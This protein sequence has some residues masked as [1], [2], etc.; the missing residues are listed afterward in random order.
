MDSGIGVEHNPAMEERRTFRLRY[1][2]ARFAKHHLPVDVL[3]DLPAFRDLLVAYVKAGWRATH[4]ERVRLPRGFLRGL[5]FDL[6]GLEDGSAV[7]ALEWDSGNAQFHLPD[8]RDEMERLVDGACERVAQLFNGA[9]LADGPPT[10]SPDAL[11]ALNRFGNSLHKDERIEFLGHEDAEGKVVFLDA[12]RRRRLITQGR[13]TYQVRFDSVGRLL[14]TVIDASASSGRITINTEEHGTFELTVSPARA[15]EEFDGK[16]M[17]DVQFRL[18]I[19]LDEDD[20]FRG[21][22][23]V[24]EIELMGDDIRAVMD[25]CRNRIADLSLL[26]DGWHDGSGRAPTNL[27]TSAGRALL[28]RNPRMAALYRI[29]PTE[30]GGLMF[31]FVR[32]GW[33]YSV[34]IGPDGRAEIYGVEENGDDEMETGT[35]DVEGQDFHRWFEQVTGG[36][37]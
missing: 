25:R 8:M 17:T 7:P 19:E 13:G 6:V 35:L 10:L 34:E 28:T 21:V 5:Q 20:R 2:G 22:A 24:L 27:A 16:M 29:F 18:I 3:L 23:E 14:G 32:N 11:Q 1:V 30:A 36:L 12:I 4:P 33:D 31:E 26:G 9:A 37:S 15:S